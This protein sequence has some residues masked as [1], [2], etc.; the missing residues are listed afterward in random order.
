MCVCVCVCV[1]VSSPALD[2]LSE[3]H[4]RGLFSSQKKK[5]VGWR[6]YQFHANRQRQ[7]LMNQ[8][9]FDPQ[10]PD[11]RKPCFSAISSHVALSHAL[12]S[13]TTGH[14]RQFNVFSKLVQL[15]FIETMWKQRWFYQ[16]V[17]SGIGLTDFKHKLWLLFNSPL[18]VRY[19]NYTWFPQ[20]LQ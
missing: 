3:G 16:C 12:W 5:A 6:K 19:N 18:V 1:W 9:T 4:K 20:H 13:L 7:I 15:N 11:S 8:K 14:R 17:P 10:S 2:D